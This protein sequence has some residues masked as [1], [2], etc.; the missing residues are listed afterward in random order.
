MDGN[1][2]IALEAQPHFSVSNLEY[3]DFERA[4]KVFGASDDNGF[5]DFSRQD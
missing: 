1:L 5:P 2:F 3:R 4:H